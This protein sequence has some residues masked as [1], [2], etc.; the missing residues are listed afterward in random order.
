MQSPSLFQTCISQ[1]SRGFW[2]ISPW[3]SLNKHLECRDLIKLRLAAEPGLEWARDAVHLTGREQEG[4]ALLWALPGL[5][6]ATTWV[7]EQEPLVSYNNW[8][9]PYH[10]CYNLQR[11]CLGCCHWGPQFVWRQSAFQDAPSGKFSH[12]MNT[13]NIYLSFLHLPLPFQKQESCSRSQ[14][15]THSIH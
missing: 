8:W 12:Y 13:V 1:F 3:L 5:T 9:S 2:A 4:G 7:L 10:N 11:G 15:F 14:I 6:V